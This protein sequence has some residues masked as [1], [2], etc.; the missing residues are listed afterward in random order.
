MHLEQ[1]T[2]ETEELRGAKQKA[3]RRG[4]TREGN[5]SLIDT[6]LSDEANIDID[7]GGVSGSASVRMRSYIFSRTRVA[8]GAGGWGVCES[9]QQ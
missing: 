4:V 1:A 3:T 5:K 9:I 7:G 6:W 2:T 8:G